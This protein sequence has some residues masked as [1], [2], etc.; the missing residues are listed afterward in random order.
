MPAPD[1]PVV[2]EA[3]R[4]SSAESV[5]RG[6]WVLVDTDGSVLDAAGEPDQLVYARS[7][8]KSI[9]AVPLITTGAA[10][11]YEVTDAEIALAISSHNG[12]P[13]HAEVAHGLLIRLG[14]DDDALRCGPGAP[15]GSA[16]GTEG[17]PITHNCSGKHAGFLT[18]ARH[19]GDDP[20]RYLDPASATQVAVREAMLAITGAD[21]TTVDTAIDGCSAPTWI[22]PL[23]SLATGLARMANP[24]GLADHHAA[25]AHR[26][27]TAAAAHPELV[28]GTSTRRFDTDALR[29]SNGRLFSKGGAE[30]VQTIGVVGAGVGFAA[31]IDDGSTRALHALTVAVLDR[32]GVL[33]DD[34]RR[35][36][37]SWTDPVRRNAAGLEVGRLEIVA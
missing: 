6:A 4:G 1:N 20:A 12:E 33:T 30:A 34:E 18:T 10:A 2:A 31:K 17:H 28:G 14:L 16:A 37:A 24:D 27:T 7:S 11:A 32:H 3:H 22:L 13:I 29:A 9:Q 36:L 15:A 23:R 5:H 26:I 21:P 35:G 8:T 19:L 25:A